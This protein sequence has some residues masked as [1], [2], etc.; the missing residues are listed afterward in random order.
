MPEV[1]AFLAVPYS[2][3]GIGYTCKKLLEGIMGDDFEVCLNAPYLNANLATGMRHNTLAP[4]LLSKLLY[5][6][7]RPQTRRLVEK[8]HLSALKKSASRQTISYIW[9]ETSPDFDLELRSLKSIIVREKFNCSKAAAKRILDDAY[10]RLGLDPQHGITDDA[11][12]LEKAR[13]E[14]ADAIFCP[15]AGVDASLE[16]IGIPKHRRLRG[17]YGFD[18]SRVTTPAPPSLDPID[19]TTYLFMGTI[20][21]RKGAH[22]MLRAWAKSGVNGRLVLA[23]ALEPAIANTCRVELARP[24]VVRLA[25]TPNVAALYKSADVFVFP[26]LEEG[27][28][29]VIYE[30]AAN[31]L[32]AIVSPMGAGNVVRHGVEGYVLDPYAEDDW[33]EAMRSLD[34]DADQRRRLSDA[35]RTKAAEFEWPRVGLQRRA[36]LRTLL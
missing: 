30:A 25:F 32:A 15:A 7:A 26:T 33:I 13:L 27:D 22:L 2:G 24:D 1:N 28:P 3:R 5:R 9:S 34:K 14:R 6:F 8:I 35:I 21:V 10:A 16:E 36:S 23:G 20:C 18:L 4:I 17:S 31:G 11:I 19:G 29:L 12:R